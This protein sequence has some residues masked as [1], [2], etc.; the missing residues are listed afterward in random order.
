MAHRTT[1]KG[2]GF[3]LVEMLIAT[4]LMALVAG[5]IVAALAGGFRVWRRASEFGSHEQ[6][7]LVAFD[8]VR[9]DLH[10]IRRFALVP[11]EGVYDQFTFPAAGQEVSDPAA[12]QEI[13]RLGYFLDERHDLL[14]RSFVP[15]RLV[16][17]VRP[18]D[19]C[20]T[21]LEGVQRVRFEYFGAQEHTETASW[22]Q[23]WE[24]TTPPLAIRAALVIQENGQPP[25][26]HSFV[27]YLPTTSQDDE[28]S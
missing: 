1:P 22:S 4:S 19:R 2:S 26:T 20:Q 12:P 11:F 15:Y 23:R 28:K 7:S 8:G 25:T 6:A 27:V 13:G 16:K 21:L 9:R 18:R 17:R 10:N 3:T 14:C 24:S 5:T